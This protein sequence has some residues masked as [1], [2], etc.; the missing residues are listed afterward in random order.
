MLK[1]YFKQNE[2]KNTTCPSLWDAA[3]AAFRGDFIAMNAYVRKDLNP[4]I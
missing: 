3:K 4:I 2:N 1:K